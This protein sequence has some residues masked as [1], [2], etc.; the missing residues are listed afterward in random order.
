MRQQNGAVV[1]RQRSLFIT[2]KHGVQIRFAS[3]LYI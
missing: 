3:A 1:D 2:G